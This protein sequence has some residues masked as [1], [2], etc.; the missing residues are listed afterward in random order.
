[1]RKP[2][3]GEMLTPDMVMCYKWDMLSIYHPGKH[4]IALAFRMRLE[5]VLEAVRR[6]A[7]GKRVMDAACGQANFGILLAEEGF[8]VLAVD[9]RPEHL[10]YSKLKVE[11]EKIAGRLRYLAANIDTI[12]LREKVDAI[13]LGELIE[14][15]K[16]PEHTL[17]HCHTLLNPGG[18]LVVTTPN[19]RSPYYTFFRRLPS[20]EGFKK[21]PPL[22]KKKITEY[23]KDRHG[24]IFLF[25][26][27]ELERTLKSTGYDV[28]EL[29]WFR[30]PF[31][32]PL[33][34]PLHHLLS[35]G[36]I[37]AVDGV[38]STFPFLGERLSQTLFTVA[39]KPM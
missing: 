6:H 39:R 30:T 27:D 19:K 2:L 14:H 9:I 29:S 23:T 7:P 17:R 38:L 13:I 4:H 10:A 11:K 24:H 8:D 1:M 32:L 5:R 22:K 25:T 36:T 21:M 37:T 34:A 20:F 31:I 26:A 35:G 15:V 33:F 28:L 16:D 3:A 12:H 18:I